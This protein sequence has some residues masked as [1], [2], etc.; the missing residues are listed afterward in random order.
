MY[1]RVG[2]DRVTLDL[3]TILPGA[4]TAESA[5]AGCPNGIDVE[6]WTIAGGSHGPAL[7]NPLWAESIYAFF[8]EHPKPATATQ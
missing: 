1:R 8:K 6:L 3:D 2:A 4:E 7:A 5:Y